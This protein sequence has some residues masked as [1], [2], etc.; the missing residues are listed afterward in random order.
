MARCSIDK[1]VVDGQSYVFRDRCWTTPHGYR[2]ST[3]DGQKLTFAFYEQHGRVPG[4]PPAP[5]PAAT[6][7]KRSA[8][9]A[10][11]AR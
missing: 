3:S 10:H 2:V 6:R 11:R 4:A 7:P 5:P 8:P 9:A 1:L